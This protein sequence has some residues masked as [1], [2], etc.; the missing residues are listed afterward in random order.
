MEISP[1][2][3]VKHRTASFNFVER[4]EIETAAVRRFGSEQNFKSVMVV[5]EKGA[6]FS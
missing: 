6:F 5:L 1:R 4:Q 3:P 2:S